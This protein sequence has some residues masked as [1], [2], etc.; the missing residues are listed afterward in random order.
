MD[1][2]NNS[3]FSFKVQRV[4]NNCYEFILETTETNMNYN[5]VRIYNYINEI[6]SK[7]I[8]KIRKIKI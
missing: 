4:D 6:N 8:N 1:I 5:K 2:Y 3:I 7:K